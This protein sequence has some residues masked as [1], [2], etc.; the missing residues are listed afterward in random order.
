[1]GAVTPGSA[2]LRLCISYFLWYVHTHNH[3]PIWKTTIV[4]PFFKSL[5][6]DEL[7]RPCV[8]SLVCV[9]GPGSPGA[10]TVALSLI[11]GSGCSLRCPVAD[12]LF[13]RLQGGSGPSG[14]GGSSPSWTPLPMR[15][16]CVSPCFHLGSEVVRP[17][18]PT[19]TL[20]FLQPL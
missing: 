16:L 9:S 12:E 8:Y 11:S 4:S 18:P 2:V 1:L 7:W 13:V 15:G 19:H 5:I 3:K 10:Q 6:H 14:W 17:P 20:L